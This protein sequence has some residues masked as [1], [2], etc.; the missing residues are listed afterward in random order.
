MHEYELKKWIEQL[1]EADRMDKFYKSKLFM[2][3]RE[4][5]LK[6]QRNTCQLCG[7]S[8]VTVHHIRKVRDYPELALSKYYWNPESRRK[9]K[10]L[11]AVCKGCHNQLHPEKWKKKS[12]IV[13]EERW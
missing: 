5:V 10:N 7:Q 9:E 11:I 1:I 3:I 13:T 6:E 12:G 4:D 2:R 8:A